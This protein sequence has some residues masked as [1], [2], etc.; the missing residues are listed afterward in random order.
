MED[1]R[2]YEQEA[3]EQGWVEKDAWKGDP[4]KHTD[5]KTFVERGDK[6]AGILKSRLDKQD[7][8]IKNLQES[9]K[10]FGEYHKQTLA[11]T[12]QA[13]ATRVAALEA[14]LEQAITDGDGQAY[15]K[16]NREINDL[17]TNA[18]PTD[19]A[20]A[21]NQMAQAWAGQNQWYA[22]NSKLATYADGIS[23]QLRNEGY[24]G[25][26][27]F[28]E[29]SRRVKEDFPEEFKNPNKS[30]PNGVD[31]GGQVDTNSKART[32]DALD[33]DAKKA[34][35]GFVA[36]GFMTQDEYVKQYEFED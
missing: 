19:D 6:I 26:A 30:R 23:D 32:Y 8:Q 5:A 17:R 13:N 36:D 31:E 18:A 29:L 21:W 34:C 15:T 16:V 1:E 33:A 11:K 20:Q 22:D 35:D 12:E 14:E 7:S 9:N 3:S 4:E 28:S 27:Y 10:Q 25:Q 24:N 2:D